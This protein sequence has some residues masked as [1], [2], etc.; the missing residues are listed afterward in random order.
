MPSALRLYTCIATLACLLASLPTSNSTAQEN[1]P[2][3]LSVRCKATLNDIQMIEYEKG[4]QLVIKNTSDDPITIPHPL[5]KAG[6]QY[7]GFDF[8]NGKTGVVFNSY[9]TGPRD[10]R[11][12]AVLGERG[13]K[14]ATI[15]PD[16]ILVSDI[17]MDNSRMWYR[18][19]SPNQPHSFTLVAKYKIPGD[20]STGSKEINIAS[21][22]IEVYLQ[23][24]KSNTP[25][26]VLLAGRP[27]EAIAMIKY[28]PYWTN[29]RGQYGKTPL[30]AAAKM[31]QADAVSWLLKNR[32]RPDIRDDRHKSALHVT[33]D[34][35]IVKMLIE[36]G[37]RINNG[38]LYKRSTPLQDATEKYATT[39]GNLEKENLK[40]ISDF[41]I[42]EG[43]Y[44]DIYS[45]VRRNDLDRIKAIDSEPEKYFTANLHDALRFAAELCYAEVCIYLIDE[46]GVDV[47][48]TNAENGDPGIPIILSAL[49]KPASVKLLLEHGVDVNKPYTCSIYSQ[50]I[51][52]GAAEENHPESF[53]LILDAGADLYATK[54]NWQTGNQTDIT[55]LIVAARLGKTENV[56]VAIEHASFRQASRKTHQQVLNRA[57]LAAVARPATFVSSPDSAPT[58]LVELLLANGADANSSDEDGVTVSQHIASR[59]LEEHY[60]KT[61]SEKLINLVRQYGGETDLFTAVVMSDQEAINRLLSENPDLVNTCGDDKLPALGAAAMKGNDKIVKTLIKANADLDLREKSWGEEYQGDNALHLAIR[62]DQTSV[63]KIL[64]EAGINVDAITNYDETALHLAVDQLNADVVELL[65]KNGADANIKDEYERTPIEFL[66]SDN[67]KNAA[68]IQQLFLK[69]KNK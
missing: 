41:L 19:P 63:A 35:K 26:D 42:S 44:Y 57:L 3:A 18:L 64:I 62:H 10:E 12:A 8:K 68:R 61:S 36:H 15:A 38:L 6:I 56:R 45:A 59:F 53:K 52:H 17:S 60:S 33:S 28:N 31:N 20:E 51:L 49:A 32:A 11:R 7:L 69:Y 37:A 2:L 40:A 27:D 13:Y 46:M 25:I 67:D 30:I 55:P 21:K 29:R 23:S 65:L 5:S 39:I 4:F 22:P 14:T 1:G 66:P 24:S 9:Q 47:N 16:K 58:E 48:Q 54:L 43:A 34:I 50:T